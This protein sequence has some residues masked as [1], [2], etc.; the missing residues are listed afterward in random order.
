MVILAS[1]YESGSF[2]PSCASV[3]L[4]RSSHIVVLMNEL[5]TCNFNVPPWGVES[6]VRTITQS[7]VLSGPT[8]EKHK[9]KAKTT[10]KPAKDKRSQDSSYKAG[11]LCANELR[12]LAQKQNQQHQTTQQDLAKVSS[13]TNHSAAP[14]PRIPPARIPE[15]ALRSPA[16]I[17]HFRN[18]WLS[19]NELES[20]TSVG[21]LPCK[22]PIE[23]V[24]HRT[25]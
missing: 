24:R 1:G 7:R 19:C 20:N 23:K 9:P 18:E 14:K 17:R 11:S 16:G 25:R 15:I 22:A 8:K 5:T 10:K 2:F 6:G 12:D 3:A 4:A 13:K 21:T